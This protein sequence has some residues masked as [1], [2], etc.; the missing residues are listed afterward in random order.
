VT[1]VETHDHESDES[2]DHCAPPE[3]PGVRGDLDP[4]L[5][6]RSYTLEGL[7]PELD[8]TDVSRNESEKEKEENW[9]VVESRKH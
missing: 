8:P 6:E 5:P 7:D 9:I 2:S 3:S 1:V 4:E